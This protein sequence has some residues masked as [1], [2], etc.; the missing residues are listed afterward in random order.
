MEEA[1][2]PWGASGCSLA[3]GGCGGAWL[4]FGQHRLV[5]LV[6]R[7][8]ERS[9]GLGQHRGLGAALEQRL[10]PRGVALDV[11]AIG[12]L[13]R[14]AVDLERAAAGVDQRLGPVAQVRQ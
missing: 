11:L 10:E 1:S 4:A 12:G 13:E 3:R 5:D 8:L 14:G 7:V 2:P 6:A 9:E